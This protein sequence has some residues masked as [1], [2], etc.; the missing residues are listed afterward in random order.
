M[1][2]STAG[3]TGNTVG[4][5][6]FCRQN[7]QCKRQYRQY[8]RQERQSSCTDSTGITAGST[9]STG[10]TL[11][12]TTVRSILYTIDL[13]KLDTNVWRRR[14]KNGGGEGG[15]DFSLSY[16]LTSKT[17]LENFQLVK[18]SLLSSIYIEIIE[19]R[20]SLKRFSI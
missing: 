6:G 4:I 9:G 5:K 16:L 10:S 7:W 15:G 12:R 18:V 20:N 2:Y 11:E 1:Q 19:S 17:L 13:C 14:N 8:I 3:S